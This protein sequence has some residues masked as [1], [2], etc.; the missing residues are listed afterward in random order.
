MLQ[1][2]RFDLCSIS[3]DTI[4]VFLGKRN[5]GISYFTND[6][7]HLYISKYMD[8]N[9]INC[10][11]YKKLAC[12]CIES[13]GIP[14]LGSGTKATGQTYASYIHIRGPTREPIQS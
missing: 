10:G 1:L 6:M 2:K 12:Y 5:T 9:K 14:S 7:I 8:S 3:D 11:L 13:I 4:L